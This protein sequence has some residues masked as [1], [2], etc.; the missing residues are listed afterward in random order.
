MRAQ[1][2]LRNMAT[3]DKRRILTGR[4]RLAEMSSPFAASF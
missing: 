1:K 3:D 2:D 4:Q